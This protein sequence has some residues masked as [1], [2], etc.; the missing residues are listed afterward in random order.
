MLQK[1]T[2]A[3]KTQGGNDLS[4]GIAWNELGDAYLQN[5]LYDESED[6]FRKSI[7]ALRAF[8]GSTKISINMPLINLAFCHWLQWRLDEPG[9]VFAEALEDREKEYG[10]DG[11]TSLM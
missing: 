4:L 11:K 7:D 10:V 1:K 9:S 5:N 6:C 3:D 2:G 8:S